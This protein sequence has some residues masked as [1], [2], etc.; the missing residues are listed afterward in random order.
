V[1]RLTGRFQVS[2]PL[3]T[4]DQPKAHVS[5]IRPPSWVVSGRLGGGYPV[6]AHPILQLFSFS[7]VLHRVVS[8]ST[9]FAQAPKAVIWM[10]KELWKSKPLLICKERVSFHAAKLIAKA[11]GKPNYF[12]FLWVFLKLARRIHKG[13]AGRLR[14]TEE[15]GKWSSPTVCKTVNSPEGFCGFD[16]RH[17]HHYIVYYQ[18]FTD[19]F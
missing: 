7:S 3:L 1:Y 11:S 15:L 19:A 13:R 16:S 12:G 14:G 17:L 6:L 2:D 5:T 18:L 4:N 8:P 10:W 9:V